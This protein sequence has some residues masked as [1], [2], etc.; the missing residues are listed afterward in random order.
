M[1]T[2]PD[3]GVSGRIVRPY[4]MTG[5]RSGVGL[6]VIALEALV[7]VTPA[8]MRM[9]GRFRWEAAE[10][11]AQSRREIAIVELAAILEVPV[12]VVRVLAIDLRDQGAITITEPPVETISESA[13]GDYADLL[14]KVLDGIRA[15]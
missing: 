7:A 9:R 11:I 5:G 10:I 8:G 13:D 2:Q 12:G 6:P 4:T 14:H 15:L 3:I 1:T